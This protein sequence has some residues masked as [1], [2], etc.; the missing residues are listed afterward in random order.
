MPRTNSWKP[1]RTALVW[2]LGSHILLSHA[3]PASD[4]DLS[5]FS[6]KTAPGQRLSK[7]PILVW[8]SDLPSQCGSSQEGSQVLQ[9]Q[10]K[11]CALRHPAQQRCTVYTNP[12]TTHSILGHLIRFCFEGQS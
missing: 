6:A 4:F 10:P 2:L 9:W 1:L 8:E 7:P 12:R 5:H 11:G 3:L